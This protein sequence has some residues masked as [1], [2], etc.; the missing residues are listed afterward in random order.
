M[1]R[2]NRPASYGAEAVSALRMRKREKGFRQSEIFLHE[3]EI[4]MLDRLKARLGLPSRSAAISAVMASTN[5][6]AITPTVLQ[7]MP[8]F[9]RWNEDQNE[10]TQ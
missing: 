4:Q 5:I 7:R 1:A 8:N 3:T 2:S 9:A 6:D 10:E